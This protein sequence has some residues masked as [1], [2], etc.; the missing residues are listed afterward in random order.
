MKKLIGL[1]VFLMLLMASGA[2]AAGTV[3][4]QSDKIVQGLMGKETRETTYLVTFGADASVPAATAL[5]S[6]LKSN[7]LKADSMGGWWILE[8][9]TLYG[10]T[11]PTDN[12]DLYLYR[13]TGTN[14]IDVLGGNG[15]NKI[16]NA[17]DN[18]FNPA[19]TTR[20][21][22]GDELFTIP[23]GTNIVNNATVQIV[24]ALYR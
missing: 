13:A 3:I 14:R 1:T 6:I 8:V 18:T 21:L 19:T 4:V 5:D 22:I 17:T 9:S 11:G 16:D 12:T 2:W 10:A 20:P 23:A 7:G 24:M 15:E